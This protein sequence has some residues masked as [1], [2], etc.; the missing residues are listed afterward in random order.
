MSPSSRNPQQPLLTPKFTEAR[1]GREKRAVHQ[2]A[3]S[4]TRCKK[5]PPPTTSGAPRT[6]GCVSPSFLLPSSLFSLRSG[7][8]RNSSGQKLQE[9]T[10][11][12]FKH[13]SLQIVK[14]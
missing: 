14:T 5:E 1:Q 7:F 11:E 9:R 8:Q 2:A 13:A 4:D 10:S 6:A 3:D 12:G